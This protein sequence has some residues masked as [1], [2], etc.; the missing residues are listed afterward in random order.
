MAN[1]TYTLN[2]NYF[3]RIDSE[4]KAY[5]LGLLYT[6]GCNYEKDGI[7]KIDLLEEDSY[8]LEYL[9]NCVEYT[10]MVSHY[11]SERKII[12]GEYYDCKPSCRLQMRN[13]HMSSTLA[14]YGVVA[15]KSSCGKYIK[16]NII[17]EYLYNHFVRGLIDGDG[18]ISYWID[19]QTTGHK[20]FQINFCSTSD[21]VEKL[22]YYL[23]NHFDCTPTIASRY[24]DRDNNNKQFCISGNNVVR[25]ITDWLYKDAHYYLKRKYEKY[26]E[27]IQ[28]N[29]RK[30][31]DK[32]LYGSMKPRRGVIH[33]ETG[34]IYESLADAERDT[35]KNRGYICTHAKKNDGIWAY[36]DTLAMASI[37]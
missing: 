21:S 13:K 2:A 7:I 32:N 29:E 22:A 8:I 37:R 19:N 27:L 6:D 15:H 31:N 18:G 16:D 5:F 34:K 17:P 10:E 28:E 3:D 20:K 30:I 23:G 11:P 14:S 36:V 24:P 4:D 33:L 1:N 9:K 26:Q 25:R 12:N 35:G